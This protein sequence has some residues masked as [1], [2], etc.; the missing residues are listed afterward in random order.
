M[1]VL[2]VSPI[3][4]NRGGVEKGGVE[5]HVSELSGKL[6]EEGGEVIFFRNSVTGY[7]GKKEDVFYY[8]SILSLIISAL[9][10]FLKY[11]SKL[12][13][14]LPIGKKIKV[15]AY[16]HTLSK[17]SSISRFDVAH[18]HGLHNLAGF[19]CQILNI[20]HVFTDH[21]IGHKQSF[22]NDRELI[23]LNVSKSKIVIAI[24]D[25]SF[26][27][28][29]DVVGSE[30]KVKKIN[31]PIDIDTN[32]VSECEF[33]FDY[34]IFN[35]ISDTWVR[36]GLSKINDEIDDILS[37]IYPMKLLVV[38]EK[39]YFSRLLLDDSSR[40]NQLVHIL[41]VSRDKMLSMVKGAKFNLAPSIK[42]GF[43]IAYL[44]SIILGTPVIGFD[45]N[46]LEMNLL[47]DTNLNQPF[48]NNDVNKLAPVVKA[49]NNEILEGSV[50]EIE[51][52]PLSWD[53]SIA[54]FFEVYCKAVNE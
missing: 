29:L 7:K 33:G 44:E 13:I 23:T 42:E 52:N 5:S 3:P 50:L 28:V 43:S 25:E 40:S 30:I 47:F 15:M 38:C 16:C 48:C 12:S 45:S 34:I 37:E 31:N 27:N 54:R 9:L 36:K 26:K 21:G 1:K 39:K 46:I 49:M 19:A 53:Y 22:H 35:G 17:I 20:P 11:N 4:I 24:S 8:S 51:S 14:N 10:G 32:G 6:L 41:P 2:Q 18:I